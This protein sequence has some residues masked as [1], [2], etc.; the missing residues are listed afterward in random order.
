[1]NLAGF[2]KH[3][4]WFEANPCSAVLSLFIPVFP[5][6]YQPSESDL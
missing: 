4:L 6:L 2:I 3:V 5:S 1:M